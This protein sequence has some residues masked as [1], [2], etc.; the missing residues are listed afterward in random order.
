MPFNSPCVQTFPLSLVFRILTYQVCHLGLAS[1][2]FTLFGIQLPFGIC[3]FMSCQFRK[4]SDIM[5]PNAF[6]LLLFPHFLF[7]FQE[8]DGT[9]IKYVVIVPQVPRALSRAFTEF[10]G[11]NRQTYIYFIFPEAEIGV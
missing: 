7:S 8:S 3:K 11:K 6:Q 10:S 5:T 1:F 9:N 2:G 4:F